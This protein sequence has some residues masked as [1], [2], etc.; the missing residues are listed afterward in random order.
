[1]K[2]D[3]DYKHPVGTIYY[4]PKTRSVYEL[5]EDDDGKEHW[6]LL[7]KDAPFDESLIELAKK[8]KKQCTN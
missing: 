5:M 8:A 6:I 2:H 1:M 3:E 7:K 4:D